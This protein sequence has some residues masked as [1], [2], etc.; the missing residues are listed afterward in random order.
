M[1]LLFHHYRIVTLGPPEAGKYSTIESLKSQKPVLVEKRTRVADWKSWYVTATETVQIYDEGGQNIYRITSPVFNTTNSIPMLMHDAKKVTH[2]DL[3]CTS[4][5]LR[6]TLQHHPENQIVVV[7]THIDEITEETLAKNN[8]VIK[9]KF[10]SVIQKVINA[11]EVSACGNVT[12]KRQLISLLEKQ[13]DGLMFFPVSSKTFQGMAELTAFVKGILEKKSV[14]LP[15]K[16]VQLFK[17]MS[18]RDVPY[19]NYGELVTLFRKLYSTTAKVFQRSKIDSKCLAAVTYFRDVGLLLFYD[20]VPL[21]NQY[22]FHKPKFVLNLLKSTFHHDLESQLNYDR[23]EDLQSK[24]KRN[25][26]KLMMKQYQQDGLLSG[27]LLSALWQKHNLDDKNKQALQH[28]L[29][30]FNLCHQVSINHELF[31]FPWFV[32]NNVCPEAATPP[33]LH[34]FDKKVMSVHFECKFVCDIPFNLFEVASVQLQ[35][36]ATN[37]KYEGERYA[38]RDGLLIKIDTLT[39]ILQRNNKTATIYV[40]VCGKAEDADTIWM[41]MTDVHGDFENSL[42]PYKGVIEEIYFLCSH[43]IIKRKLEILKLEPQHV[44]HSTTPDIS[45]LTCGDDEFPRGL[46]RA[47]SG[48]LVMLNAKCSKFTQSVIS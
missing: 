38:W 19:W 20:S 14:V 28:L 44:L 43:C 2:T 47:F 17:M 29:E 41:V 1:F 21:L 39:C 22:V 10:Q 8:T 37:R 7:L 46:V 13:K 35:K 40:S 15:S 30:A 25:E 18:D 36:T 23:S 12:N 45:F 6:E 24:F 5:I 9:K 32:Q 26:L 42:K 27:K 16:W 11:L 4:Q 3:E 48:R 31:Y 33:N 34:K